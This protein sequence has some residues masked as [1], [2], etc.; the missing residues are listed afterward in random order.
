[1]H[2]V[3]LLTG[4]NLGDRS[5]QLSQCIAA[6]EQ[7]AGTVVQCSQ[8]Y[9]TEAW[10]KEGLPAHLNQA[11]HLHTN[12]G[13]LDLLQVIHNIEHSLGRVRQEKWGIRALDIDIIYYDNM[14][15]NLPQLTIPHPLL[16]ERRFV[17]QPLA[18]I[19]PA[20]HHPVFGK[21]N[22]ELL[23]TC[24]DPLSVMPEVNSER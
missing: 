15:L 1:M 21:S 14:V 22:Y 3:F 10:G 17:L 6:L 9:E 11:L 2:S 8:V 4:S 18:E 20:Y 5:S 7:H 16:Q 13:P 23:E 24:M 19:A 12:L